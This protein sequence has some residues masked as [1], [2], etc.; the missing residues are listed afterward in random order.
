MVLV[1]MVELAATH[2]MVQDTPTM[3][4][5]LQ[6]T[7]I[8]MEVEEEALAEMPIETKDRLVPLAAIQNVLDTLAEMAHMDS[9]LS[10]ETLLN[11]T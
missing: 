10:T 11:K 4:E 9:S 5:M 1:V 2:P 8:N 7:A 3:A 6:L